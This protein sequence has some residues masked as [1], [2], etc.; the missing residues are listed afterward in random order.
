MKIPLLPLPKILL[1]S[2]STPGKFLLAALNILLKMAILC[3]LLALDKLYI[4]QNQDILE[5]YVRCINKR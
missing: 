5:E 3:N 2:A 1:I 4:Q